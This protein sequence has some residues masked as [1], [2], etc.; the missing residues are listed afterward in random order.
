MTYVGGSVPEADALKVADPYAPPVA[1]LAK[2]M[3][4]ILAEWRLVS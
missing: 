3:P 2:V 1:T 4:F